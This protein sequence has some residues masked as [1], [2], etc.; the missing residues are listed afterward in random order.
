MDYNEAISYLGLK[1]AF[2]EEV[3]KEVAGYFEKELGL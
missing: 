1:T 3:I 2:S